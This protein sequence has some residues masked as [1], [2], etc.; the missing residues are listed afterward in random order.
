MTI[1]GP[2]LNGLPFQPTMLLGS[3][4]LGVITYNFSLKI[5]FFHLVPMSKITKPNQL[6]MNDLKIIINLLTS[7][8][9]RQ[10]TG[11]CSGNY[12]TR[13]I[14]HTYNILYSTTINTVSCWRVIK[15][16]ILIRNNSFNPL[17]CISCSVGTRSTCSCCYWTVLPDPSSEHTVPSLR[18]YCILQKRVHRGN[19]Y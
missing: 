5:V 2:I 6:Q 1:M 7:Q 3:L 4:P 9:K 19:L 13:I 17:L 15:T 18:N 16:A 10:L 11:N 14:Y 12:D 8:K